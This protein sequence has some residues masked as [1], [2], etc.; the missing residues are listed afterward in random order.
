MKFFTS[1]LL[2]ILVLPCSADIFTLKDGTKLDATIVK[3]TLEEYELEVQITKSLTERRT[4]KRSDVVDIKQINPANVMFEE[5]IAGL[6]PIPPALGLE[7]YNSRI[8]VLESFLAEHKSTTVGRKAAAM[9]KQIESERDLVA[10]GGLRVAEG[11]SG[12]VTAEELKANAIGIESSI[13]AAKFDKLVAE[14]SF[15]A[16][17]RQ[18]ESLETEFFGSK[19]QREAIPLMKR[20]TATYR[21]LLL[22]ELDGLEGKKESRMSAVERLSPRDRQRAEQIDTARNL[23]FEQQWAK[24]EKEGRYW[25]SVD[26]LCFNSLGNTIDALEKE[27]ERLDQLS[28]EFTDLEESDELYRKGWIAAGE[29]N[30]AELEAILDA[31][32]T[33]GVAEKHIERLV[34][35]FQPA[36]EMK[37]KEM[38]KKKEMM[39]GKEE[40]MDKK[41][42]KDAGKE[43]GEG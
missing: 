39:E 7:D 27:N 40:M 36:S 9:L 17:L 34:N 19:A 30:K 37:E 35:R 12:M 21:A 14:R 2:A 4:I 6:V 3:R 32:E 29:K 5:K 43:D 11:D 38:M 41:E 20:L 31:M 13:A 8:E 26:T 23:K 1:S 24:E 18:Y 15:L 10:K 22:R 33:N 25:R 42:M 16:A 28:K